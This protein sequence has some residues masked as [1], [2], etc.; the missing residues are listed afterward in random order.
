MQI[1]SGAYGK[2]TI[3]MVDPHLL[4]PSGCNPLNRT[5]PRALAK[6]KK[7]VAE[8]GAVL[9]PVHIT[10]SYIIKDGHRRTAVAKDLGLKTIPAIVYEDSADTEQLFNQLNVSGRAFKPADQLNAFLL[11]GIPASNSIKEKGEYLQDLL[12]EFELETFI[13]G[14]Y[15]PYVL[16]IA[17]DMAN[18]CFPGH[19]RGTTVVRAFIRKSIVWLMVRNQQQA[20]R[21]Y[22]EEFRGP[23]KRLIAFVENDEPVSFPVARSRA[24]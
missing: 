2:R 21:R 1:S 4:K 10:R 6:L 24:L 20:V 8:A 9:A 16:K 3:M 5:D 14:G 22:M 13:E 12:S 15:G 18:Y 19:N 17:F 7:A 11:G 23:A